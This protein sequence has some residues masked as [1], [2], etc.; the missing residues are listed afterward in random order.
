[1]TVSLAAHDTQLRYQRS[2]TTAEIPGFFKQA[3]GKYDKPPRLLAS[4]LS[5]FSSFLCDAFS[6]VDGGEASDGSVF[7]TT[8]AQAD[9]R[10]AVVTIECARGGSGYEEGTL[11]LQLALPVREEA[12]GAGASASGGG[13]LGSKWAAARSPLSP[14][15]GGSSGSS[16][17]S[18][19]GGAG[20]SGTRSPLSPAAPPS[21]AARQ[22]A[23]S[24]P[25]AAAPQSLRSPLSP[26]TQ[27]SLSRAVTQPIVPRGLQPGFAALGVR[28][29]LSPCSPGSAS[30]PRGQAGSPSSG[31]AALL[32]SP[33]ERFLLCSPVEELLDV[34]TPVYSARLLPPPDAH[35]ATA[36]AATAASATALTPPGGN[37][38]GNDG[39]NDGGSHGGSSEAAAAVELAA[40]AESRARACAHGVVVDVRRDGPF[41]YYVV[42]RHIPDTPTRSSGSDGDE[43]GDSNGGNNGDSDSEGAHGRSELVAVLHRDLVGQRHFL[44][45]SRTP[46]RYRASSSGP[47]GDSTPGPGA[48]PLVPA[49]CPTCTGRELHP[50][51]AADLRPTPAERALLL[52]LP[53]MDCA[54][55]RPLLLRPS[56]AARRAAALHGHG[57]PFL[58]AASA[59]RGVDAGVTAGSLGL[60]VSAVRMTSPLLGASQRLP[61]CSLECAVLFSHGR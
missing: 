48:L 5:A 23:P 33:L 55:K 32:P 7:N 37:H 1:M 49:W 56:I 50:V 6:A 52:D 53:P 41:P 14:G 61:C 13:A 25:G 43:S 31:A 19:G 54:C 60:L 8:V 34:G 2:L 45:C 28:S 38:G 46:E 4:S 47:T 44:T 3:K 9:R 57:A 21:L 35:L 29:P 58:P 11:G 10:R 59:G 51:I 15:S 26:A 40:L 18:N 12:K 30:V 42:L 22:L 39:G 20:L 17:G 27:A 16:G 24:P 36:A